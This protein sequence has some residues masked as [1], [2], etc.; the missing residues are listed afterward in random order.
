MLQRARPT[1]ATPSVGSLGLLSLSVSK[2]T[3]GNRTSLMVLFSWFYVLLHVMK[4]VLGTWHDIIHMETM[5]DMLNNL[6]RTG[7][8]LRGPQVCVF[9]PL[10]DTL[11]EGTEP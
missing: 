1:A 5:N 7:H 9:N 2:V 11:H 10:L 8:N 6:V 3:I 4:T